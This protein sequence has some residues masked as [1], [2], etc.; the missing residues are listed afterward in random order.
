MMAEDPADGFSA[1]YVRFGPLGVTRVIYAPKRATGLSP[2]FQPW[3]PPLR[4][5]ALK[6]RQTEGTNNAK[7]GPIVERF[8][9]ALQSLA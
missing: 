8:N 7:V 2:G 1:R 3:E 9:C 6:G 4:R 5:F